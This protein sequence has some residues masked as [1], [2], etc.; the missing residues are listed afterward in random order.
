MTQ[1]LL[2]SI[3]DFL[4]FLSQNN[5]DEAKKQA[6][7]IVQLLDDGAEVPELVDLAEMLDGVLLAC[8]IGLINAA[9]GA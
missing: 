5:L 3:Y 7:I 9:V 8:K 6:T 4:G 1:E 2:Q